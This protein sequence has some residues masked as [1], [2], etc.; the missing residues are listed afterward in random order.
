M[1]RRGSPAVQ[2]LVVV[3]VV[4]FFLYGF[5]SYHEQHT[6]LKHSEE[7]SDKCK[8][9]AESLSAQ[10]QVLYEHKTR[11]ETAVQKEKEL[12]KETKEGLE[13]KLKEAQNE[14][15]Q[16]SHDKETCDTDRESLR[17]T[18]GEAKDNSE[19]AERDLSNL[20]SLFDRD[21]AKLQ[22]EV[23]SYKRMYEECFQKQS[24]QFVAATSGQQQIQQNVQAQNNLNDGKQSQNADDV[25]Q[26]R[27]PAEVQNNLQVQGLSNNDVRQVNVKQNN[28]ADDARNQPNVPRQSADESRRVIVVENEQQ[29]YQNQ[30]AAPKVQNVDRVGHPSDNQNA[31]QQV[32]ENP[33]RDIDRNDIRQENKNADDRNAD[34]NDDIERPQ[35]KQKVIGEE[36]IAKPGANQNADQQAQP[37]QG[38]DAG[39]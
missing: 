24:Q 1:S 2:I 35:N 32:V 17:K 6:R 19:K 36:Q 10:L 15:Y 25:V 23:T 26:I 16:L 7:V 34:Y 12:H 33:N 13:L 28:Q 21:V 20:Q 30:N 3:V 38:D 5:Y 4:L 18:A 11:L 8:Q 29:Q 39:L 31:M 27:Q 9:K 22:E 37:K 14:K